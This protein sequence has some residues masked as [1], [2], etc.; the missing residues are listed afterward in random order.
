MKTF[1]TIL[2]ILLPVI[3]F[4]QAKRKSKTEFPKPFVLGRIEEVQSNEL[5]EKRILNIYLPEGYSNSDTTNYP[6]LYLLDGSADEDFI[7]IVGLVQFH[8]F[9]WIK[10]IPKSIVVGIA[11]VDRKRDFTFPT[12]VEEDKKSYPTTGHS[13]NFISFLQHELQPY[14]QTKYRT[15]GSKTIIGQSLG[16]L[17]AT[18]ILFKKPALFNKY[19]IVS[20]SLWWNNGSLLEHAPTDFANT[21]IYI[22][23]GKE[24]LTPSKKP[25]VMEVDANLLSDKIKS[26]NLKNVRVFFDYLTE[27]NHATILHPAVSN[28]F[29]LLYSSTNQK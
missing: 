29:K 27:E 7:H 26:R 21:D 11:S 1:Y 8:S 6:V 3:I 23:V 14:I 9:E 17:L 5:N 22:G 18:E 15:N 20:P 19:I 2:L 28:A 4:G 16:G 13:D 12:H 25:R 24:G 10:Q